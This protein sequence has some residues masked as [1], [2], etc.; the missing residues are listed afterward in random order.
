[1]LVATLYGKIQAAT[2]P[3]KAALDKYCELPAVF[4]NIG[5]VYLSAEDIKHTS[6]TIMEDV[7]EGMNYVRLEHWPMLTC[8]DTDGSCFP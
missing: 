5:S 4:K 1:M 2:G 7:P 6:H 8:E 3:L